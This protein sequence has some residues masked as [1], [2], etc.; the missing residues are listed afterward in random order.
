M[1]EKHISAPEW[2]D[3]EFVIEL[4][5]KYLPLLMLKRII[6]ILPFLVE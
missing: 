2:L 4:L 3:R 6:V 5:L 1:L